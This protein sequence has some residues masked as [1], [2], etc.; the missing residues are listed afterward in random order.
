MKSTDALERL[1]LSVTA[2]ALAVL[3]LEPAVP[4][5]ESL[6]PA[7][8]SVDH[9]LLGVADLDTGIAWVEQLTGVRASVGGSHPG[10]GTR[11][12]LLSLGGRQYVEILAPDPAQPASAQREDLLS[13]KE[14]RVIAWAA[15]ARDLDALARRGRD[16]GVTLVGPRDGARQRPD[17]A[18]LR[19]RTLN[20]ATRLAADGV[21]PIPFF[22]EWSA[23]TV[24]PSQDS[25]PG[26][27][28]QTFEIEHPNPREVTDTLKRLGIDP[29]VRH[30]PAARLVATLKTPKG[31]VILGGGAAEAARAARASGAFDVKLTPQSG[32]EAGPDAPTLGRMSI[33]KQFHGDLQGTSQGEM[34]TA[35]GSTHKDSAGYVA[36]ERVTGTL[37]G[38]K[39][40][41][42]LQ[43]NGIMT[44]GTPQL[45]I[46]VVPDSGTGELTGLAGSMTIRIEG[47]KHFYEFEYL[48][49]R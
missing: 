8:A 19:W 23:D 28:L 26:C 44:R 9:L 32:G 13:L 30:A 4:A 46:T 40:S 7:R 24:H 6:M 1:G 48:L 47:K 10:R 42:A 49:P 27:E 11:N 15:A 18:T 34:L 37:H 5:Q 36:V 45:T 14:P 22:I 3:I 12:A 39:G 43:H 41:F 29:V 17:G 25:P 33:D 20:P 21:D 35:A 16:A 31:V 38:R 2:V